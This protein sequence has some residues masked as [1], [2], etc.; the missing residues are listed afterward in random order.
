MWSG[1]F[2]ARV[3]IKGYHVLLTGA[4]KMPDEEKDE[5]RKTIAQLN[6]LNFTAYNKIILSQE[7]TVCFQIIEKLKIEANEYSDARLTWRPAQGGQ[8]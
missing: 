4:K 6:L 5:I 2:I 8:E 3:V 7:D 1:N